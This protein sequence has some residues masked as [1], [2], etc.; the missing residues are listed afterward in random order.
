MALLKS[1]RQT[2]SAEPPELDEK[3]CWQLA[4]ALLARKE[5]SSQDLLQKLQKKGASSELANQVLQRCQTERL[6]SDQRFAEI[7]LR[8]CLNKGQGLLLV[9]QYFREHGIDLALLNEALDEQ[10]VDWFA[11]ARA[12]YLR[13]FATTTPRDDKEKLKRMAYLSRKGFNHEQIRFATEHQDY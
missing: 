5:L 13:K 8:S 2:Q 4:L 10:Q 7:L 6:Q 9:R 12:S 3:A 1:D 11:Q